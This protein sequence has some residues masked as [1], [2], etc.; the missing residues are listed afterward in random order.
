MTTLDSMIIDSM[1]ENQKIN[2]LFSFARALQMLLLL[3]DDVV[4]R[5]NMEPYYVPFL[6]DD[7]FV[8]DEPEYKEIVQGIR[9]IYELWKN[10]DDSNEMTIRFCDLR[11][12]I[13]SLYHKEI[14]NIKGDKNA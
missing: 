3:V 4:D 10:K 13:F 2:V 14:I 8:P 9:N 11:T 5:E 12:K 7:R 1:I 6:K